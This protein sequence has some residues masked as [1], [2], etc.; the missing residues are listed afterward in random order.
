[1]CLNVHL[2]ILS[3]LCSLSL[4]EEKPDSTH[5]SVLE[6]RIQSVK[7]GESSTVVSG[8]VDMGKSLLLRLFVTI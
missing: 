7:V 5:Q 3:D 8:L 1:M 4:R 6:N 2:S